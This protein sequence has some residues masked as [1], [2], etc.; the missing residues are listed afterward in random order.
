MAIAP[1]GVKLL[2]TWYL[3]VNK[4]TA[5]RTTIIKASIILRV[6]IFC[7]DMVVKLHINPKITKQLNKS[8]YLF[9]S[10]ILPGL[11]PVVMLYSFLPVLSKAVTVP[12]D[13]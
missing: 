1:T 12:F 10:A 3:K 4:R 9:T 2:H 6:F 5:V 13:E 7:N 11:M 8:Y